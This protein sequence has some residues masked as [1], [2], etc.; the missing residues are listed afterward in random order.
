MFTTDFGVATLI[1]KEIP[2][3]SIASVRVLDVQPGMIK[4]LMDECIGFCRAAGADLVFAA[5]SPELE[6]YLLHH[7]V[8]VMRGNDLWEPEANLFPVTEETVKRWREIYNEK[9]ASVDGSGTLTV[10]DEKEIL[11]SGGAYFVHREG[12][13]LGIGWVEEG[14]LI[15]VAS[16][17]PGMGAAVTRTLLSA[18]GS[19]SVELEVASTNARAIR[20]YEALGFVTTGERSA[21]YKIVE[22]NADM[23]LRKNDK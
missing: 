1:L 17:V 14:K 10:W 4:E 22:R 23:Q 20:L 12:A 15:C 9:M 21:W 11:N 13:L 6:V 3:K 8:R 18:Q 5:G 19:V 2:Y 16:C 7:S